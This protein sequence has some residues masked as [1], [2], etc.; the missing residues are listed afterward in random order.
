[1][2][3]SRDWPRRAALLA[4]NLLFLMIWGFT[5]LGKL[6]QGK[7]AWFADKFGNTVL[8]RFPGLDATFW[9]LALGETFA[10]ALALL[11]LARAEFLK[12]AEPV[13]LRWM[14]VWSL[15]IFIQLGFG[16]WLTSDFNSTVQLFTY[17][18]GVLLCL[19]FTEGKAG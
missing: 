17:F 9:L 2:K 14:L 5:G 12:S 7:P 8:A 11:A 16:Q 18:A 15:F 1:M 19:Q 6:A 4:I 3:I 13:I 10:F